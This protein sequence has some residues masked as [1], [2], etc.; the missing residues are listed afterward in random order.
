MLSTRV[1]A[2]F[3][4]A[5]LGLLVAAV[6]ILLGELFGLVALPASL[7]TGESA[8]HSVVRLAVIGCVFAAI[9]SSK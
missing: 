4:Y 9:G 1:R 3:F 5:G 7:I 6:G 8:L 2:G